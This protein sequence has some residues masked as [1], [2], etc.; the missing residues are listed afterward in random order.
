M[1]RERSKKMGRKIRSRKVLPQWIQDDLKATAKMER[2]E[3]TMGI[4]TNSA[5]I[6]EDDGELGDVSG[7]NHVPLPSLMSSSKRHHGKLEA[8]RPDEC[9]TD[10]RARVRKAKLQSLKE[11]YRKTSSSAMKK[12]AFLSEK[13]KRKKKFKTATGT[14]NSRI[15]RFLSCQHPKLMIIYAS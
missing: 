11:E 13:K 8:Q 7:H 10:F 15:H 6:E 5:V 9:L 14:L 4:E 12:K 1:A 3:E 2:Q